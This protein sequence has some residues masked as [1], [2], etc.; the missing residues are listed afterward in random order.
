MA[1]LRIRFILFIVAVILLCTSLV[2]AIAYLRM[3]REVSV[4]LNRELDMTLGGY[5]RDIADWVQSRKQVTESVLPYLAGTESLRPHLAQ[6][7]I[8]GGFSLFYVGYANRHMIYS[9]D[10]QAAPGYDLNRP[11]FRGGHFV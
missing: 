1:S 8:A 7:A 4:G 11:G 6:A 3:Q 2:T 10:K 5:S 9:V